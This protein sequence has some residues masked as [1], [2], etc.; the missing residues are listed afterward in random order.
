MRP[1]NLL[2]IAAFVVIGFS[3]YEGLRAGLATLFYSQAR[4]QIDE[5]DQ[6]R[7][8]E[9]L[10]QATQWDSQ[11]RGTR[12]LLARRELGLG[13]PS[14]ARTILKTLVA[15]G[16]NRPV[17]LDTL[18]RVHVECG[19]VAAAAQAYERLAEHHP[20]HIAADVGLA[21]L[22]R[23]ASAQLQTLATARAARRWRSAVRGFAL[24]HLEDALGATG[25]GSAGCVES[26]AQIRGLGGNAVSV[27]VPGRQPSVTNPQITYDSESPGGEQDRA[28]REVIRDA[29]AMGLEVMLKPHI[30]LDKITD[31]EWR[32]VIEFDDDAKRSQWW[33]NYER[34]IL[35]YAKLA[36][37]ESVATFCIGVELRGMVNQSPAQW[38]QLIRRT[39]AIYSGR[40]T[41]AANWYYEYAEVPFWHLLDAIGVQFFFPI[42][43]RDDPQLAQLK[44]GLQPR[45]AELQE[46]SQFAGKPVLFTEVGYKSTPGAVKEPWVWPNDDQKPDLD[47]Q[48][49]AYR[50]ILELL[51]DAT[52]IDGVFWW[53]WLTEP[54]PGRKFLHD[55]TP[56]GK[57]AAAVVEEFWGG[58]DE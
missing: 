40:L 8:A 21:R 2:L 24:L 48:A 55:F 54:A 42:T 6:E 33:Q 39:R 47:L 17:A 51:A 32:G 11:H 35:H 43:D 26:L 53:N 15:E 13:N 36:A 57:P 34:F 20:N 52:W 29:H 58:V 44:A 9:L 46:L 23:P 27:R 28:V 14:Q 4:D 3:L 41:Y 18:A 5:G 25:Y 7:G 22:G 37:A 38:E 12:M 10:E 45:L 19:E 49:R 30:M 56:Q 16:D 50:A 31:D 1:R